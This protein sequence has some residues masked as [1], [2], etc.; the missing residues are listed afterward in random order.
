MIELIFAIVV[1]GIAMLA[2]PM[3]TAQSIKG[4]ESALMQESIAAN[5]SE[6][7][8]ILAKP[9]D[10]NGIDEDL[11]SPIAKTQSAYFDE[12]SGLDS[13]NSRTKTIS[14]VQPDASAIASDSNYDDIGDFNGKVETLVLYNNETNDVFSGDYADTNIQMAT[15]VNFIPDKIVLAEN[16]TFNFNPLGSSGTTTNIK[17]GFSNRNCN[18]LGSSGT[19]TNIKRVTT[20]LTVNTADGRSKDI[21]LSG[22]SCNIGVATPNTNGT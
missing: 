3:I 1:M 7:S 15:T 20:R 8:M 10:Q 19:T 9:W 5:A 13:N 21:T 6:M 2:I 11:G 12:R 4:A 22:F 17:I 18:A 14:G 16:T